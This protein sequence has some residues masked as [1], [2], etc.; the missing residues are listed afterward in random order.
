MMITGN[1]IDNG[2]SEAVFEDNL[3]LPTET[4][5]Q[6]KQCLKIKSIGMYWDGT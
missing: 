4:Q 3:T 6:I 5:D 1:E 2:P